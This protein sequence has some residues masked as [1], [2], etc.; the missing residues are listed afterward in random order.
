[1]GEIVPVAS[2]VG[3]G[4]ASIVGLPTGVDVTVGGVGVAVT[5]TVAGAF[6]VAVSVCLPD[7]GE[8]GVSVAVA[9]G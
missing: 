8:T 2:T 6:G 7:G 4:V 5:L 1:V 9:A 3:V